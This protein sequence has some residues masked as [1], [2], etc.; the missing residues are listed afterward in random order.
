MLRSL[1]SKLFALVL[2]A[3]A[4]LFASIV[5]NAAEERTSRVAVAR[6]E[7]LGLASVISREHA[8]VVDDGRQ[9][10]T[11]LARVP[12]VIEGGS[13]CVTLLQDLQKI[14]GRYTQLGVAGPD[15][16]LICSAVPPTDRVTAAD[17][18]WF[19]TARE[20]LA[21]AVGDY[22]VGRI[23]GKSSVVFAFPIGR[24]G[25][26]GPS[27]VFAALDL[28]WLAE[29][30]IGANLPEG[31]TLMAL[32]RRGTILV[33]VPDPD[34]SLGQAAADAP[35]M[36]T[37]LTQQDGTAEAPALDGVDTI[38]GFRAIRRGSDISAFVVAGMPRARV[39][40]TANAA[41]W[42]DL[43]VLAVVATAALLAARLVARALIIRPVDALL[44]TTQAIAAGNFAARADTRPRGELGRLAGAFN[45]MANTVQ[46]RQNQLDASIET[47]RQTN[48]KLR[49]LVRDA[50]LAIVV[51]DAAGRVQLWNP[52]AEAMFGWSEHELIGQ[53]S[54]IAPADRRDELDANRARSLKGEVL[55]GEE[56]VRQAR[57]GRLLDVRVFSAALH[58]AGGRV[59]GILLAYED[60]TARKRAEGALVRS[61]KLAD[62][63][64]LAAGVAHELRN[65]LT[66][67]DARAQLLKRLTD[68][69][70]VSSDR[71]ETN[72]DSL[73]EAAE[74][75]RRIVHGLSTYGK[76]Q[77]VDPTLV[78]LPE[79]L[80]A[81]TELIAYAARNANVKVVRHV[82]DSL[83]HVLADRSQVMQ[84]LL[85]LANNA[86]EAMAP[87][88]G[89]LTLAGY[90][91]DEPPTIVAEIADTGPGISPE[92]LEGIW[93]AFY[94][95]KAEGTGLGL[96]I[97]RALVAEQPGATISVRSTIGR[98]TVF[99]LTFPQAAS[100]S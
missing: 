61:E 88:G 43:A 39:V 4:P 27:V 9:F 19:R 59:N 82:P 84:I 76:P 21:F 87:A 32:D 40:A 64:R 2:A 24:G 73:V 49:S 10:L 58:D 80:T 6:Q 28:G 68:A 13:S 34:G 42:R 79:L 81:L 67:V 12:A 71:L 72:V 3:I 8:R 97:V 57:D 16:E 37:I 31:A 99:S 90:V 35:I 29:L 93:T 44:E 48:E 92:Q 11:A 91:E 15:G 56:T 1:N 77:R 18:P 85:N 33:R 41:L 95:T 50:P 26:T 53:A 60:I 5:Y 30:V 38:W 25:G 86:L 52:A 94:T 36:K 55:R 17:R 47:L 22:Q 98:G 89:M 63:G 62:L 23:T 83:P 66:V 70:P 96:S 14:H 54:P 78:S 65:P 51:V 45:R 7:A 75:M 46:T 100:P 20:R 74:R 69:G